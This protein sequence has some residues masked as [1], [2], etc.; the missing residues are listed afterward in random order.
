MPTLDQTSPSKFVKMMLIGD[1]GAG[2]TGSLAPLAKA[3]Y[4]LR[5][6]D[7]D[8]G[9]KS[10]QQLLRDDREAL[11]R[12]GFMSFRDKYKNTPAGQQL[13]MPARAYLDACRAADKWEDETKPAEWGEKFILVLDSLTLLSKAAFN[14]AISLNPA[15]KHPIQW[16]GAAQTAIE[17]FLACLT[18]E[19]FHTNVIV[20]SHITDIELND[21]T[22]RGFPTTVG[23][24]LSRSIAR[25][26]NDL[27][28]VETKGQGANVKRV[29]RTVPNG[30]TDA[31]ASLTDL[32][33]ELPIADGMLTIFKKLQES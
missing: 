13:V 16:Y 30:Q 29:I 33:S 9:L 20:I 26:F 12:V 21:G 4:N 8:N 1:S 2:K 10:L 7:M 5:F 22:S 25:Y 14:Q 28:V 15:T 32:P 11:A 3:G 31:K 17:N 23:K 6:L 27:F 19:E 24:A 18:A